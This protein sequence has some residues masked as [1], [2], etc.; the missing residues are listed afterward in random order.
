MSGLLG[1]A[2]ELRD[3]ESAATMVEYTI[4]IMTIALACFASVSALG[5]SLIGL[6]QEA[7]DGFR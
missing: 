2:R 4:M 5:A 7:I 1:F 3:D 6:I